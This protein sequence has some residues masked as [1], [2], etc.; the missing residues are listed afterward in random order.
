M[1]PISRKQVLAALA[2]NVT[3]ASAEALFKHALTVVG[4]E[5]QASYSADEV[6]AM[7]QAVLEYGLQ[8]AEQ[9]QDGA[10][11]QELFGM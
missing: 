8:L 2:A 1:P 4:L 6:Q 5:D 7:S 3:P 9:A 11:Q 10:V